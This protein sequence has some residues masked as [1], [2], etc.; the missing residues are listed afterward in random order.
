MF[1]YC[2]H[3]YWPELIP[4]SAVILVNPPRCSVTISG[5]QV[6][7]TTYN[8]YNYLRMRKSDQDG[9]ESRPARVSKYI[10]LA[11]MSVLVVIIGVLLTLVLP[12]FLPEGSGLATPPA[13]AETLAPISPPAPDIAPPTPMSPPRVYQFALAR[14]GSLTEDVQVVSDNGLAVLSLASGTKVTDA[15]GQSLPSI[16]ITTRRL[17]LRVD[18]DYMGLAYEFG[19]AGTTLDPPAL[20]TIHYNPRAP[21]PFQRDTVDTGLVYLAYLGESGPTRPALS[22]VNREEACISVKVE[23]LGAFVPYCEVP[24]LASQ[25]GSR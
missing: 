20:L 10:S 11:S 25:P 24:M 13:P 8:D 9:F 3:F 15:Q 22:S 6:E 12:R 16:T 19:P 2:G 4:P 1:A 18:T 23:R 17:Q 14:D 5:Y 7:Q 21:Y